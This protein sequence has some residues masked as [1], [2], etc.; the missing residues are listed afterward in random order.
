MSNQRNPIAPG[1]PE[2]ASED[3]AVVVRR[4][5][6]TV[7]GKSEVADKDNFFAAGHSMLAVSFMT[8]LRTELGAQVPVA[9]VFE[10]PRF[11]ELVGELRHWLAHSAGPASLT[12]SD[13]TSGPV[14]WQQEELL[15]FEAMIGPSP[16]NNIVV[17]LAAALEVRPDPLRRALQ[18]VVNRHPA[19]RL[20]FRAGE[21][22]VMPA[23]TPA[24]IELTVADDPGDETAIRRALRKAHLLPFDLDRGNLLRAQLFRRTGPDLIAL[25]LHHLCVDGVSQALLLDDLSAAYGAFSSGEA[26]ADAA[27]VPSYLDYAAWQRAEQDG[28]LARARPYWQQV[29]TTLAAGRVAADHRPRAV[30]YY[31]RSAEVGAETLIELRDWAAAEGATDFVVFAAAV[32]AA[33]DTGDRGPVGLGTLLDNRSRGAVERIVGPLATSTLLAVDV[34]TAGTPRALVRAT[35]T[36]LTEARR[37]TELPLTALLDQPCA[38][39]GLE[40]A[41]LV[42]VVVTLDQPYRHPRQTLLPLTQVPDHG[43]PLVSS[44]LDGPPSVSLLIDPDNTLTVSAEAAGADPGIAQ[45]LADSVASAIRTFAAAPDTSL[46]RSAAVTR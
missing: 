18:W 13:R 22:V 32:A 28:L 21:Q 29:A 1:Q 45:S 24:E 7:L 8:L 31:R 36:Q 15:R 43:V 19:L 23:V 34:A 17:V 10:H 25:H 44:G 14:S 41:D 26:L 35:W 30:R 12:A 9:L 38:E 39:L 2:P 5:W 46:A 20:A 40:P 11:G 3:V 42:D 16:V 37:C 6:Q 33:I 27:D 4:T